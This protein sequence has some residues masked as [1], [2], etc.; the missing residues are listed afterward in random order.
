MKTTFTVDAY[1]GE[2]FEGVVRQV[3]NAPQNVQNVVTYN[4]VIDVANPEQKLKPGMT[5]NVTFLVEERKGVLRIP[6]AALRF[7]PSARGEQPPMQDRARGPKRLVWVLRGEAPVPIE[8]ETGLS[9]GSFTEILN[10]LAA[11]DRLV[12]SEV[13]EGADGASPRSPSLR[14]F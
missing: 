7:R 13:Q 9:D 11:G 12:V 4:A 6:N 14:L 10:G 3:R 2:R 1:P 8:V 5:A